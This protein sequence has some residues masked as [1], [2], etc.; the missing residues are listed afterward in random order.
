[1]RAAEELERGPFSMRDL[2]RTAETH[3]TALGVSSDSRTQIQSHRLGGIQART[4]TATAPCR[5]SALH[6]WRKDERRLE[7][8]DMRRKALGDAA[9]LHVNDDV[10]G[11]ALFQLIEQLLPAP[12]LRSCRPTLSAR[13]LPPSTHSFAI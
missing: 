4:T 5:R 7:F 6:W 11:M 9:I 1:M 12:G 2:R 10:R 3:I 8:F 13:I